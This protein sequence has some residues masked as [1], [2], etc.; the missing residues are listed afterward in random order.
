MNYR[1]FFKEDLIPGGKGDETSPQT[2]DPKQLSMEL[3]LK[4]NIPMIH[5]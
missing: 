1:D 3:K 5:A 4:W 2:V